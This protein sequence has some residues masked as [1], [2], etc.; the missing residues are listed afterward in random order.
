[1][2][3]D[4]YRG[5]GSERMEALEV[6]AGEV[7]WELD[8]FVFDALGVAGCSEMSIGIGE[9]LLEELDEES[10]LDG[11]TSLMLM[12]SCNF[13]SVEWF[14]GG[15][16][17]VRLFLL[18]MSSRVLLLLVLMV[19]GTRLVCLILSRCLPFRTLDAISMATYLVDLIFASML[20]GGDG[21]CDACWVVGWK[22]RLELVACWWFL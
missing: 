10:P 7:F 14:G 19:V 9:L 17:R 11:K 4:G 13:K 22:Y 1:M 8:C 2:W 21:A 15:L 3:S 12:A 20:V 16:G 18:L 6:L 5:G